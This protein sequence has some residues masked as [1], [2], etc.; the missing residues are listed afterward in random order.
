[1]HDIDEPRPVITPGGP[2][3][4]P[5][6]LRADVT[7]DLLERVRRGDDEALNQ[8]I[9]RCLPALR[10]WAHGRLP[11]EGRGLMDTGDLVQDTVIAALRQMDRFVPRHQ[12]ALQAYLRMA[13]M[14]RVRDIARFHGRRPDRTDLPAHMAAAGTSPLDRLIGQEHAER[15]EAALGRLRDADREAI[16]ARFELQYDYPALAVVLGKPTTNAAR[17]AVTRAVRR[18]IDEL[19]HDA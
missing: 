9:E 19:E 14:N 18:L 4:P 8:V 12:G 13:L 11:R 3:A 7:I 5:P 16:I 6:P 1:M 10:R 2:A 15:F 17:V